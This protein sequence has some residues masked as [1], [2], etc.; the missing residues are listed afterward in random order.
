[1]ASGAAPVFSNRVTASLGGAAIATVGAGLY[2]RYGMSV[3]HADSGRPKAFGG[4]PAFLS[5]KL[6]SSE[7]VNHNTKKLRFALPTEDHVS[8]LPITSALLTYSWPKGCWLPCV[9]P[10]TPVSAPDEP[11]VLEFLIKKYPDGKQSTHIH[12]LQPGDSLRFVVPIPGYKWDAAEKHPEVTLVAGGAGIT[13]MY[14][15]LRGIFRDRPDEDPRTKVTLVY[16]VN[17]DAD[18]LLKKEFDELERRHPGRFRAVYT[19]SNPGPD[20][21][22]RKG[23]V[24]K[25]LLKEVGANPK[26]ANSKVFVCGPPPMEAAL[27]NGKGSG[28]LAELGYTKGQVHR[29]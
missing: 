29:F 6:E 21:P 22:Y 16:G 2:Y 28:I 24:T 17:T 4:G 26:T 12:S 27:G 10:Y 14:Q 25:E 11:G 15:L 9:R 19:V 20:S 18:V 8:G 3:A 13:P 5:L 23:Y 7:L 1:M